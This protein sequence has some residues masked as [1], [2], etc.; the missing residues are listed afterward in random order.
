MSA[1]TTASPS[2]REPEFL[3]QTVVVVGGSAGIRPRNGPRA[4]VEG[5]SAVHTSRDPER[6]EQ[7]RERA[8]VLSYRGLRRHG[9]FLPRAVFPRP[10]GH[11]PPRDGNGRPHYGRIIDVDFEQARRALDEHVLLMIQVAPNACK[12]RP[13]GTL[14]FTGGAG[15]RGPG[16]GRGI[17]S[18]V[19]ATTGSPSQPGARTGAVRVNLIAAGFADTPL[20]ASL[21]GKELENRRKQ[22]R[23][24][25]PIGRAVGPAD[26]AARRCTS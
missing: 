21:L 15:A 13:R 22:L 1:V 12:V 2:Q 16:V 26:V 20:S 3:G 6:L 23:G 8:R 9:Y 4:S 25:L 7:R 19:T 24:T 11:D 18:I 5:A 14:L 10:A 17:M